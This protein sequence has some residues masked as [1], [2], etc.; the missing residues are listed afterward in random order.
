M[1]IKGKVA[2]VTGGAGALGQA[3][4][5]ALLEK[6]A[7]VC[8]FDIHS[9]RGAEVQTE[10][11]NQFGANNVSFS[12]CDVTDDK[13]F[14]DAF[15]GVVA[16]HGKVDIMVNNAAIVDERGDID[17]V[18]LVNLGG[19][20]RGSNLAIKH[21]R[22]DEGGQGGI[23]INVSSIGG[24]TPFHALPSYVATKHGITGFTRSWAANPHLETLGLRFGQLCPTF[25]NSFIVPDVE[26]QMLYGKEHMDKDHANGNQDPKDIAAGLIEILED[27][28]SN[29]VLLHSHP[30]D[31]SRRVT[32][33]VADEST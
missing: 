26:K 23:V 30:V 29:G 12:I 9:G 33:Q 31:G 19:T 5:R 22:R 8:V 2:I 28:D 14:K 18:L 24:F 13:G 21:M 15:D 1:Q 4:V 7:K 16:Q 6:E 17:R 25:F 11:Q 27:D 20:I 3:M 10:L 32:I